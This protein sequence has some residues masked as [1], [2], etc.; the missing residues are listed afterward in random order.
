MLDVAADLFAAS[1][2]HAVTVDDIG[3]A[4]GVSG[5]ALYHHFAGKDALL[6]EILVSISESLVATARAVVASEA[7]PGHRVEALIVTHVDFA[8]DRPALIVVQSRDL[9]HAPDGARRRVRTLQREY[10]EHWV[11]TLVLLGADGPRATAR[12]ATHAAFGL[13]NS[14]PHSA[15]L[16]R[17][18]MRTLLTTMT[19]GALRPIWAADARSTTDTHRPR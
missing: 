14:T 7:D 3:A 16:G 1:G 17:T 10:V 6:G 11:D 18:A 13:I 8:L 5:P 4:M 15:R 2:Y 19:L 9:G 12:A